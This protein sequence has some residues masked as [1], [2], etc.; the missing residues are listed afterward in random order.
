MSNLL[1]KIFIIEGMIFAVLG[2]LFIFNPIN[3]LV[4]L[5]NLTG[6][7]LISLGILYII[8]D[9]KNL[10]ISIINIILGAGLIAMPRESINLIVS[11]YG[12]WSVVRGIYILVDALRNDM[13][14]NKFSLIYGGVII[15]LG[16]LILL[17]PIIGFIS[18][19][20]IIGSYF[21][22]SGLSEL[23]IGFRIK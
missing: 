7:I 10:V 5:T 8:R 11:F 6:L 1:E 3:S 15:L 16:L 20:Y 23:Y 18:V 17:N 21:I 13:D 12:A 22:V 2:V 9:R 4:M 14:N 19:P